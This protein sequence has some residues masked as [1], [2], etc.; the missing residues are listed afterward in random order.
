MGVRRKRFWIA[1]GAIAL[2]AGML[3]V[4]RAPAWLF[5]KWGFQFDRGVAT[6]LERVLQAKLGSEARLATVQTS[7][8]SVKL[9]KVEL[10]L[11]RRG[12]HLTVDEAVFGWSL[13]AFIRDP[14]NYGLVARSLTVRGLR[15]AL[16]AGGRDS[17]E[18]RGRWL[19]SVRVPD[20]LFDVFSRLDSLQTIEIEDGTVTL[21]VHNQPLTLIDRC[22]GRM[23]R[24]EQ[25]TFDLAIHGVFGN[26]AENRL[27]VVGRLDATQR[28][29]DLDGTVVVAG[30][31]LAYDSLLHT[32]LTT[33]GG[34][35]RVHGWQSVQETVLRGELSLD[36]VRIAR[37]DSTFVI[38]H[39]VAELQSDSLRAANVA[40]ESGFASGKLSGS[41]LLSGDGAVSLQAA[42]TSGER[43][44][45]LA[46][47]AGLNFDPAGVQGAVTA[48]GT[49]KGIDGHFSIACDSL[50]APLAFLQ[51][52]SLS[53]NFD[54]QRIE[55]SRLSWQAGGGTGS[56]TGTLQ[57]GKEQRV[58]LRAQQHFAQLP[59]LAGLTLSA[60]ALR[61]SVDGTLTSPEV[62]LSVLD[63]A[64]NETVMLRL[65][66]NSDQ[67]A[68]VISSGDTTLGSVSYDLTTHVSMLDCPNV[69]N[70]LTQILVHVP[71]EISSL[72]HIGLR[73]QG[74]TSGGTVGIELT[75]AANASRW[76]PVIA[77]QFQF[78]G[79][80]R[81]LDEGHVLSG[82]WSGLAGDSTA[83][84]G[85]A[86]GLLSRDRLEIS[87][88][89]IDEV[90]Q[91]EGVIDFANDAMDVRT[92][93]KKLP[94]SRFPLKTEAMRRSKLDG[95]LSG[96][97]ELRGKLSNPEWQASFVLVDGSILNIPGYWVNADGHGTFA[98]LYLDRLELGRNV[99][100][101][102][103]ATGWADFEAGLISMNAI[104]TEA[105]AEDFVA[106][107]TG[108]TKLLSGEIAGSLKVSGLLKSPSMQLEFSAK[109]GEL[110][111]EI[112]F[113]TLS[114]RAELF[115]DTVNG[116]AIQ[117]PDFYFG[118]A[119]TYE[120]TGDLFSDLKRGG[121]FAAHLDGRGD[122]IDI[123]DQIDRTAIGY[124][125]TSALSVDF[126]GT[127]DAPKF[128]GAELAV[129]HGRFSYTDATPEPMDVSMR[130]TVAPPG[131]VDSGY[132]RVKTGAS[133][134]A[135]R[136]VP[137]A[138]AR[139][140]YGLEP[141]IIPK[142]RLN[143]GVL[144]FRTGPEGIPV[145]LPGFMKKDWTTVLTT[146]AGAKRPLC[147]SAHGPS[148]LLISA[149]VDM[150]DGRLTFPFL[151]LG[152]GVM[153]PVARWLFQRLYE[154]RW[155]LAMS[156]GAGNHYDVELTNLKDSD[157][158]APLR[159]SPVLST[160]ADYFDHLSIDALVEPTDDSLLIAGVIDSSTFYLYGSLA[161]RR[162]RVEYLDQ[163]FQIDYAFSDFDGTNIMPILEGRS[164]TFGVDSVGRRVPVYLTMYQV[165]PETQTRNSRGRLDQIVF[166]LEGAGGETSEKALEYLGYKPADVT[167]KA[168]QLV[169]TTV[170][171]VIG[172]QWIDPIERKLERWTWLDEIAISPGGG[173]RTS[174]SRQYL[175]NTIRQDS[176]SELGVVRFF[177]GSQLSVGKYLTNEVFLSY[178]GELAE[179]QAGIEGGRI[180]LVHFWNLEYRMEPI[181]PDLVLDLG[182]EYDEAERRR[183]ESVSLKY[184]FALEP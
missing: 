80:Y 112:W 53:G 97:A 170:A 81:T 8:T 176:L 76:I 32:G 167:G 27:D 179:S 20:K 146:G 49:L 60:T 38:P 63:S 24:D 61:L 120:F 157:I 3:L 183:D 15:L 28:D 46:T 172:R 42:L 147:I 140:R 98:E 123:L 50:S 36:S 7:L 94:Y 64:N 48:S 47:K 58:Q 11:D 54:T 44:H 138:E 9:V 22:D 107:L 82:R 153:R 113:D 168:E 164:Y 142:P 174:L 26:R 184:S 135:L 92:E 12:S 177:T 101:I 90:G 178:T 156:V 5:D 122:F 66:K 34:R 10:P 4:L 117:I 67:L 118:K 84:S 141:L 162:G 71:A 96:H 155:D 104:A 2:V 136:F 114:A 125:S 74:D 121:K 106:A 29:F 85:R 56:A 134:L 143:L 165:D 166:M 152:P 119:N 154:A 111:N 150:R 110:L 163:T 59:E 161:T 37:L 72:R 1:V 41:L 148:R 43:A 175:Q 89:F 39:F 149:D 31:A 86:E 21:L 35:L 30:G 160:L 151:S 102:F 95:T 6:E 99:S 17:S 180:G 70:L 137:E 73:H 87:Q 13:R 23:S 93:I 108:Q 79:D 124:G 127:T 78:A 139:E 115:S 19:E 133:T 51:N 52:V 69:A 129:E 126:G 62:E 159:G 128:L 18:T 169:A 105:R 173:K 68:A 88:C 145:T 33:G 181:S 158:F 100:K 144:E 57:L 182:V 132:I 103:D 83:F 116:Q 77:R 14:L 25:E 45:E 130:I 65:E 55:F 16:A 131:Q 109:R 40:F 91:V 75:T 171:R